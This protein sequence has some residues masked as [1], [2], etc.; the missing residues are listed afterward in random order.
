MKHKNEPLKGR[1]KDNDDDWED[2]DEKIDNNSNNSLG[3]EISKPIAKSDYIKESK[4]IARLKSGLDKMVEDD[5]RKYQFENGAKD[6]VQ[7]NQYPAITAANRQIFDVTKQFKNIPQLN[8]A[9]HYYGSIL[10]QYLF[11]VRKDIPISSFTRKFLEREGIRNFRGKLLEALNEMKT[12][13]DLRNAGVISEEEFDKDR[14][15]IIEW[16]DPKQKE[17]AIKFLDEK[18]L[19]EEGRSMN[20][21]YQEK[22][23]SLKA[24]NSKLKVV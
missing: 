8:A 15:D 2:E 12:S 5:L 17:A 19:G 11:I 10:L 21:L 24:I 4:I 7:F 1:Y 20:R 6:K 14:L 23:R 18:L 9:C 22:H 13:L 3:D 16:F